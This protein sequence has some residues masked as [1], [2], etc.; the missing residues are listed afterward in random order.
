M[1]TTGEIQTVN[2]S[3]NGGTL[4]TSGGGLID[5]VKPP[6]VTAT[7]SPGTSV[8]VRVVNIPGAEERIIAVIVSVP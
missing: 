4:L 8:T 2:G 7:V 6:S 1:N 3:G 5:F